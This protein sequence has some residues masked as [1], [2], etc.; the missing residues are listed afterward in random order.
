M[1]RALELRDALYFLFMN[2]P[3]FYRHPRIIYLEPETNIQKKADFILA[4]DGMLHARSLGES[5]GLSVAEFLFHGKPV[6]AWSGGRD[7][8]HVSMLGRLGIFY[9]DRDSLIA[10]IMRFDKSAHHPGDYRA[11]ISES[12][13]DASIKAFERVFL[14]GL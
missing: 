10:Q 2:T 8:N 7:Q 13:P 12:L 6:L 11:L 5:F 1:I 14:T 9:S 4:C 3:E